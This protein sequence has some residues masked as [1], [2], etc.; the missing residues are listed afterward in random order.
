MEQMEKKTIRKILEKFSERLLR[1]V[2]MSEARRYK[3]QTIDK[4]E[5]E[6]KSLMDEEEIEEIITRMIGIDM[7]TL[8]LMYAKEQIKAVSHVIKQWWEKK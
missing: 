5:A 1:A 8:G 3:M 6:I 2:S 7:A 4:T